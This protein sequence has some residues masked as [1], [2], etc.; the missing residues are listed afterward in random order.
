[1]NNKHLEHLIPAGQDLASRKSAQLLRTQAEVAIR[2]GKTVIIDLTSVASMSESYADELFAVLV[3]ENG[4]EWFSTNIKVL[5]ESEQS[6]SVLR[7][8][9]TA[10]RRRLENQNTVDIKASVNDLIAAKKLA[11]SKHTGCHC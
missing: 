3:E 10:I 4:L 8:I 2:A 11:L 6:D 5:H 1:M 9:A 7:S